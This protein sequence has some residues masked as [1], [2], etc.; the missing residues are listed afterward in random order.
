MTKGKTRDQ[1]AA[2]DLMTHS[3]VILRPDPSRTVIRPFSPEDPS[4]FVVKDHPRA[5]RI[6]DRVL[7]MD[8]GWLADVQALLLDTMEERHRGAESLFL[9][10]AEE[11]SPLI[12]RGQLTHKQMLLIGA[13]FSEEYSFEAAALFNPSIVPHPNQ[14]GVPEGGLRFILSLRGI[15]EGHVSSV[16]FRTGMW[17]ADGSIVVDPP[18]PEGVPPRIEQGGENDDIVHL[19]C[20]DSREVSETVIFPILPSQRQGVEDMRLVRF[21][22]DDGSVHYYGTYTAFS[23]ADVRSELLH[24]KDFRRFEMHKLRGDATGNKGM[25]LFPRRIDGRYR[26]IGRQDNESLW[27]LSSDDLHVWNGGEKIVSPKWPWEFVQMGNCGSPIEIDEGWLVMTHGVGLMRAYCMGAVLL[28]KQ[29]PSKLLARVRRPLITP[30]P[31]VRGGYVPNVV[32]SC[33]SLLRGRE[34]LVPY[35]VADQFATFASVSVD[36]VLGA[37]E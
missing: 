30:S 15:G 18:S 4:A 13:Y 34:L 16:T 19:I 29:D 28:D 35:G 7:S 37:M 17:H 24:A 5:Q 6:A 33:G 21:V 11:M 3:D 22:E 36:A 2:P 10:R 1:L 14:D 26:M 25:A 12:G 32:Y 9:R 8:A 27:L 31:K 20:E 23:G